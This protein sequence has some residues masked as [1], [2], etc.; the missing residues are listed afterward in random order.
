MSL[1]SVDFLV[2]NGLVVS[3]TA[4]ILST[5][6][7]SSTTTGALTVAG[8]AGIGKD[9][10]VGGNLSLSGIKI[11]ASEA[12]PVEINY[13]AIS[14]GS[15]TFADG[16]VQSTRAPVAWT[17]SRFVAVANYLNIDPGIV[18]APTVQGGYVET[19]DTYFDD[20]SFGGT[21][22]HIY[23]MLDQGNG[24]VQFFDITPV[25]LG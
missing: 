9:L 4:T 25:S 6:N 15:I 10:Y 19:G 8:G 24:L 21:P 5:S 13:D 1:N 22:N 3:T 11:G 2:K 14:T 16:S 20:G 17:N 18:F 7:A 12:F 23:M